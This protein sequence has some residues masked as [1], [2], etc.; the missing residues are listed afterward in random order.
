M[1]N[2]VEH[3]KKFSNIGT[4]SICISHMVYVMPCIRNEYARQYL[5]HIWPSQKHA[6]IILTPLNPNFI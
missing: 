6:Y 2:S 3:E 4:W 1:L 5:Q